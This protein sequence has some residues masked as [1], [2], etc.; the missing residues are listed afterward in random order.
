MHSQSTASPE[1]VVERKAMAYASDAVFNCTRGKV[2][3]WRHQSLGLGLGTLTGSKV[4]LTILNRFGHSISYSK[5]KGL[6]TEMAYSCSDSGLEI[7]AGLR[8][9]LRTGKVTI[10]YYFDFLIL[11]CLWLRSCMG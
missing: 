11:S 6:E 3:S 4:L 7:P 9:I 5:V 10:T 8:N 1:D 2:C